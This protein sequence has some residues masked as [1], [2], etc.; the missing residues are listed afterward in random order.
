MVRTERKIVNNGALIF[1][2]HRLLFVRS[3]NHFSPQS[4]LTIKYGEVSRALFT[5]RQFL[6]VR[7]MQ[8]TLT[9]KNLRPEETFIIDGTEIDDAMAYYNGIVR[10]H[11][12]RPDG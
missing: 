3:R 2:D 10:F 12:D 1:T 5:T 8:L 9:F 7:R 11:N 6:Q 4:H